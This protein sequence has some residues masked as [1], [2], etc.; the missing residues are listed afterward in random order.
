MK[1]EPM[2]LITFCVPCFNSQD[3]MRH[4][5]DCLLQGGEDVEIIVVDDGSKDNTGKIADEYQAAHPSIV[6]VVHKA[7]GGHGSGVN[8]GVELATGLYYKVVDSDDWL[9][10]EGYKKLL[11]TIKEHQKANTLPD[12]Y[13]MDFVYNKPSENSQFE[14]NFRSQFP[15]GKIF[16]W[17]ETKPF[18]G[19]KVFLMH[20]LIYKTEPLRASH[21]ILPEHTF[22]VDDIFAYQPLPF[23][24]TMYYLPQ[25]LYMYFIGRSDQSVTVKNI[26]ARYQQQIVVQKAMCDAYTYDQ[27]KAMDKPLRRY[28]FHALESLMVVTLFFTCGEDTK[29]RKQATKDLWKYIKT[30]DP[31][32]YRKLF[33]RGFPT[34]VNYLPFWLKGKVMMFSYKRMVAREHLG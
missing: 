9:D 33:F 5:L 31:R 14:R 2:K 1:V 34:I 21:T 8:K 32:M 24:K 27:I 7:N 25:R 15:V 4:C 19:D 30:K 13:I 3:Y 16:T 26:V 11:D 12:L 28:L 22:Y 6:R 29:E 20:A 18:K 10:D 23:M 17:K